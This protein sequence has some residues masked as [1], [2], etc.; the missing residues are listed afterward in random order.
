[1]KTLCAVDT[2]SHAPTVSQAAAS[3]VAR[4]PAWSR[5]AAICQRLGLLLALS[6]GALT[7]PPAWAEPP[8]K[9]DA[10]PAPSVTTATRKLLPEAAPGEGQ[11][12]LNTL[13][14]EEGWRMIYASVPGRAPIGSLHRLL[15]L[16]KTQPENV[17]VTVPVFHGNLSGY[18]QNIAIREGG[19]VDCELK[20]WCTE[21]GL[22]SE[23]PDRHGHSLHVLSDG[24]LNHVV[25]A[26]TPRLQ[27]KIVAMENSEVTAAF[28]LRQA[29][30]PPAP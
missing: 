13:R 7:A 19:V 16:I 12:N 22:G 8:A 11:V 2:Y 9:P 6:L 27:E 21:N 3:P 30:L 26:L 29:P 17:A 14:P 20:I 4:A 10:A 15:E 28:F 5:L 23:I 24:T 18:C 25:L 1:M